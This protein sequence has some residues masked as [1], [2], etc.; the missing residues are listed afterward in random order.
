VDIVSENRGSRVHGEPQARTV[1]KYIRQE[2][3]RVRIYPSFCLVRFC[4]LESFLPNLDLYQSQM[5][6]IPST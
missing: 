2:E 6:L 4:L 3:R 5:A 1:D